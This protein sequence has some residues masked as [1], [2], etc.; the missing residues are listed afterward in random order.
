MRASKYNLT[1]EVNFQINQVVPFGMYCSDAVIIM[2]LA[3]SRRV[4][5]TEIPVGFKIV[6]H[7][8]DFNCS[9]IRIESTTNAIETIRLF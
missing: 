1:E 4:G 9:C 7:N 3:S 6:C 5:H 2:V 8:V